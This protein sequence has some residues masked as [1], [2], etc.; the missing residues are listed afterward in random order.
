[1]IVRW[2]QEDIPFGFVDEVGQGEVDVM[3]NNAGEDGGWNKGLYENVPFKSGLV[4]STK[5]Y[6]S[7]TSGQNFW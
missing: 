6:G 1:M 2:A 5:D 7:A 4:R 3:I